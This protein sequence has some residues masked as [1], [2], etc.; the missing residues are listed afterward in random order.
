MLFVQKKRY[1]TSKYFKKKTKKPVLALLTSMSMT[2]AREKIVENARNS[3]N[4]KNGENEE[5]NKYQRK[6]FA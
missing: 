5:K 2:I 3:K 1:Y 6:N 4:D